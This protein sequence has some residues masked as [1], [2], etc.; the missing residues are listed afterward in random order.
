MRIRFLEPERFRDTIPLFERCFG[1]D[2]EFEAE[3]YGT[4]SVPGAVRNSRIAVLEEDGELRAMTHLKPVAAVYPG[5]R[6]VRVTY[7]MCVSTDP[8][9]RHRG[10][11]DRV[12]SFAMEALKGEG[13]P[14]CFLVAV[15]KDIYRH[16]G[17]VHDWPFREDERALLAADDGLTDCSAA[18]LSEGTFAPPGALRAANAPGPSGTLPAG[19]PPVSSEALPEAGK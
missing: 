10:Y 4:E 2:P 14:W 17:F 5:G 12:M 15:D 11:M 1:A 9:F 13:E 18:L 16:L 3:Y 19:K 8:G 7:L 6:T